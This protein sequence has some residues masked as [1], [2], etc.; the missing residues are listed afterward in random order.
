[1]ATGQAELAWVAGYVV[2][3]FTCP[4]AV[5]H[6]TTNRVQCSA[7]VLIETKPPLTIIIIANTF[8]TLAYFVFWIRLSVINQS[9]IWIQ[10]A[11]LNQ[12]RDWFMFETKYWVEF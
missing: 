2:R 6:P 11:N 7:T 4:K 9:L 8:I 3:Q 5:T 1:M 10:N 12:S